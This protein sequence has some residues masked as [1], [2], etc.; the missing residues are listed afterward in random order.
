M[1]DHAPSRR[2]VVVGLLAVVVVGA[3]VWGIFTVTRSSNPTPSGPRP[4]LQGLVVIGGE[5]PAQVDSAIGGLAVSVPWRDLQPTRDGGISGQNAIESAVA[6]VRQYNQDNG[7]DLGVKIRVLAGEQSPK[8][9]IDEAGSVTLQLGNR[10]IAARSA[11]VPRYWTSTFEASF[12]R[13]QSLLAARYDGVAEVREV[14]IARCMT[15]FAEPFMRQIRTSENIRALRQ[16]GLDASTDAAC[17]ESQTDAYSSWQHVRLGLAVNPYV[18]FDDAGRMV[19]A[20]DVVDVSIRRCRAVFGT[21][22]VLEN[23]SIRTPMLDGDYPA[24]YSTMR[25]FG[26]PLAFQTA[27]P[28]LVGS[29]ADTLAWAASLGASYVEVV[30]NAVRHVDPSRLS[31]IADQLGRNAALVNP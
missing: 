10:T 13:L 8:W 11:V 14:A 28:K 4:M 5:L 27:G 31:T 25:R 17:L 18:T 20:P 7:T 9:V 19:S 26:P 30:P 22:C 16:A 21:R 1:P 15:I 3:V 29:M 6:S 12:A 24:L 23:N 2:G